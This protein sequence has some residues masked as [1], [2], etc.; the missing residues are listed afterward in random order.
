MFTAG[1]YYGLPKCI[2]AYNFDEKMPFHMK[3]RQISLA[4]QFLRES[5]FYQVRIVAYQ[6]TMAYQTLLDIIL[7]TLKTVAINLLF[8][9]SYV[10]DVYIHI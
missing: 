3:K 8:L 1:E 2:I 5:C 10:T 4:Y 6:G 9:H 7:V